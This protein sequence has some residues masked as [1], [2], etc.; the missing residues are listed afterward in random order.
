MRSVGTISKLTLCASYV[1]DFPTSIALSC[2][3]LSAKGMLSLLICLNVVSCGF[4]KRT[5]IWQVI[6][7][8]MVLKWV[9]QALITRFSAKCTSNQLPNVIQSQRCIKRTLTSAQ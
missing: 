4:V 6:C 5:E 2:N 1:C 9:G 3:A 7:K 8:V